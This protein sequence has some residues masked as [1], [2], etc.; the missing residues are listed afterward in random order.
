MYASSVETWDEP[1][2]KEI[3]QKSEYF[4]LGKISKIDSLGVHVAVQQNFGTEQISD[5]LL[6]D[7]FSMLNLASAS[8]QGIYFD[9]E[10]GETHYLFITKRENGNYAIPTPSSGFAKLDEEN[11]VYATYRHSYHQALISKDIYEL[12][13]KAIWNYY[14]KVDFDK[15]SLQN[16]IDTYIDKAPAGFDEN[17]IKTFFLQHAALETAYLLDIPIDF[18]KIQKFAISDNF[19]SRIS[20]VQLMSLTNKENVKEFLLDFIQSEKTENFEKVI[21]IWSLQRMN[22][23]N[24]LKKLKEIANKLSDEETGF[25]SN[26]MDPRIGTQFPSPKQAA[27]G[28]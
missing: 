1:W 16:F 3:I 9:F 11:N 8:G 22:D 17:E 2:Q 27:L 6:I 23:E 26:L 25:T 14:K 19:H 20:S 13:Y 24:Y 12:T 18:E 5:S 21:A 15:K 28:N 10:E 4:I 7:G